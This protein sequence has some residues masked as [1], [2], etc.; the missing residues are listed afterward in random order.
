M[1]SPEAGIIK[2]HALRTRASRRTR[3][4]TMSLRTALLVLAIVPGVALAALWAVT[5]GQTLLDFQRQAAQGQL[6]Q[7]AGQPS[8]IVYYNLQA[9][10]RL[11]AEALARHEGATGELQRQRKLTDEAVKSF[12]SLSD[13]ATDDAPAEVR[14][15][16]GKARAAINQLPAQRALVDDGGNDQQKAVYRYYTDL[17]AVDLQLFAALSHVDNGRITTLSQPLVDLFWTKEMISRSDALLARGWPK[18]KLSAE[19]LKQVREAVSGQELQYSTKVVP[20]LPPDQKAMWE[21]ITGSAA[22]KTK[23]RVENEVLRPADADAKGFVT[24]GAQEKTWR[25]AMDELSPQIEKLLEHRTASVVEEGKGS[26]MS[27]LFKMVLTTV[28]GLLAVI[29]VI[30]TTWRLTRN[31]RRRIGSLQ[32][33]AEELEKALPDVVE[34]LAQGERIDVEAEARA[35]EP[36]G[37]GS[38]SDELS[39]LGDALNLARTSALAAAVKQAD[40]H[41]GFERLLQRI[42]RRTQQLIG[43]QLKKLDELERKH[44]DP[45]VLDGL[46]DLDHLTARLRRY[47]ENLVILAGG[48]PHRRWRKPVPLLDVMRSAQG[49]VQDYRRVVLDLDGSPWLSERAVGPVSHVLAELIENALS[50]SRPP[51]PVEVRAAKVSRGLAIEVE[52]RG[53]GMEED[54]LA[55]ANELMMRPPRM[56]VLA[57][58]DDIRLGLYVIARLA[59]QHGLRV[60]F[61]SSAYGGTRVVLLVPDELTVPEPHTGPVGV[62]SPAPATAPA[63]PAAPAPGDALPTR[64]QGQALAGVTALNAAGAPYATPEQPHPVAEEPYPTPAPI[65]EQEPYRPEQEQPYQPAKSPFAGQEQPYQPATSPFAGQDQPYAAPEHTDPARGG[66]F[67]APESPYAAP[68]VPYATH[69]DPYGQAEQPYMTAAGQYPVDQPPYAAPQEPY[70]DPQQ[71]YAAPYPSGPGTTSLPVSAPRQSEPEHAR[72]APLPVSEPDHPAPPEPG[73]VHGRHAEPGS[74]RPALP[75][76]G[77][78]PPLPRRVR[79]AS[80]AD[81][82]RID[83][84]SRPAAPQPPSRPE[85]PLPRPEPRRA[86]AAI[87]AFQR[88]SRAA[89]AT[90]EAPQQQPAP[91]AIPLPTRE[92]RP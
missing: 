40:Q 48:S 1:T 79:Q 7:K 71:P 14:D 54:Q 12:Q 78:E 41:R 43:Q 37:K 11:S 55:A 44:E 74:D 90:D 86:G 42:A 63:A 64:V 35:I 91:P 6:A 47:E 28:V 19:D 38:R 62:P 15:A 58:S 50:F 32:E 23:T 4:T 70:P 87:G 57:H 33:R 16:V 25:G 66:A 45:A 13:V 60:E 52:D 22:W 18:G 67:G 29:A 76:P 80:L 36:D 10:R 75:A 84:A 89:R 26:V 21:K 24:L 49:E 85:K 5:S 9:E 20:Q 83:P 27:L 68:A 30:W 8:N 31:L 69:Q 39:Q 61:R 3:S 17:I 77:A 92:E 88:R 34:R 82:L 59:D 56:D 81:E 2:E 72:P 65:P 73:T 46:F 53:L 51:S